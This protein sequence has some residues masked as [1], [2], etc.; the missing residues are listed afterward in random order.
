M[1]SILE[2]TRWK[3]L[4]FKLTRGEMVSIVEDHMEYFVLSDGQKVPKTVSN[5]DAVG[6]L[7]KVIKLKYL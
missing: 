4:K 5:E 6:L 2:N 7:K 1:I 3:A